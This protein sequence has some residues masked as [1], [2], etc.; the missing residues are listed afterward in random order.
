LS[1]GWVHKDGQY[2]GQLDI[3]SLQAEMGIKRGRL[4]MLQA[5]F[6]NTAKELQ[7]AVK[8]GKIFK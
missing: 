4:E 2:K 5:T 8:E 7:K 3:S 1:E 6:E